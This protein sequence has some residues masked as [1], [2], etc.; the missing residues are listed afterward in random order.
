MEDLFCLFIIAYFLIF[1][2]AFVIF[3]SPC[4]RSVEVDELIRDVQG[5][6]IAFVVLKI[7]LENIALRL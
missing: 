2:E 3:S 5:V 7:N 6:I 4:I 1:S